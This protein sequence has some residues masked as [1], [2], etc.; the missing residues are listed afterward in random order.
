MDV[1]TEGAQLLRSIVELITHEVGGAE[2]REETETS[3]ARDWSQGRA[4][5]C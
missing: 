1:T 3:G 2:R 4:H 5:G